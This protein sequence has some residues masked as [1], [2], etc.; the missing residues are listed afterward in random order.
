MKPRLLLRSLGW[1]AVGCAAIVAVVHLWSIVGSPPPSA[2]AVVFAT[3]PVL[4]A[5]VLAYILA[6]HRFSDAF[7]P[8]PWLVLSSVVSLLYAGVT[9]ELQ[10]R[11]TGGG[12]VA[13]MHGDLVLT[14]HGQVIR[15]LSEN[16]ARAIEVWELRGMSGGLL[17]FFMISGAGLLLLA[18]LGGQPSIDRNDSSH[19]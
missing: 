1:F 14:S 9:F 2:S 10:M 3:L 4:G 6:S 11:A 8:P 16:E 7:R 13:T 15:T 18:R 19:R 12:S 17:P 5:A